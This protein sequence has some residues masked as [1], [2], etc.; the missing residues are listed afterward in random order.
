MLPRVSQSLSSRIHIRYPQ[1]MHALSLV[2][3]NRAVI[4]ISREQVRFLTL[5][6]FHLEPHNT[7]NRTHAPRRRHVA[8]QRLL[9]LREEGVHPD[10]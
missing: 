3:I 1:A 9:F 4:S 8:L 10:G 6:Q 7:T 5:I 2:S